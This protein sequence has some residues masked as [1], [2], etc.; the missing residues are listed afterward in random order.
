M[1]NEQFTPL[2]RVAHDAALRSWGKIKQDEKRWNIVAQ[3]VVD[4]ALGI[5][6][7]KGA[8]KDA[9]AAPAKKA[10]AR[11]VKRLYGRVSCLAG[12]LVLALF[13]LAPSAEA[14]TILVSEDWSSTS[15]GLDVGPAAI[16]GWTLTPSV[17]VVGPG[18]YD[19]TSCYSGTHCLDL[20]GSAGTSGGAV[21]RSISLTAGLPYLLTWYASGS[22]RDPGVYSFASPTATMRVSIGAQSTDLTL[23][24]NAP[25]G[26]WSM[27]Y[28]PLASGPT[29][30]K[31][32]GLPNSFVGLLLDDVS[33]I[34][35]TNSTQGHTPEGASL[36]LA[37][38]G[39]GLIW[40]AR[41]R[42]E[43]PQVE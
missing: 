13:V 8:K 24:W 20:D 25:W 30:V 5:I 12:A 4:A 3:A 32:Q 19:I 34:D 15:H 1:A 2:G 11:K 27:P 43:G 35:S 10:P 26:V 40:L 22:Q 18:L 28:T 31:F 23:P 37:L 42:R 38:V 33:L 36:G 14:V 39:L 21:E 29:V 9:P 17:D 41:L 16:P 7:I 6:P